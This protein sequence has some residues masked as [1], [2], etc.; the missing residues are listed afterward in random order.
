MG[1]KRQDISPSEK[2]KYISAAIEDLY[3]M[4]SYKPDFK[5]KTD[6]IGIACQFSV[7]PK[8]KREDFLP[9][10]NMTIQDIINGET[11]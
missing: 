11:L 3:R 10:L 2:M 8:L 9:I 5:P 6:I 1:R 4:R 7:D